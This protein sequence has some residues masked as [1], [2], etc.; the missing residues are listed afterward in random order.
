MPREGVRRGGAESTLPE[1]KDYRTLPKQT[2]FMNRD[3]LTSSGLLLLRVTFGLLMLNHG[4]QK[5]SGY[6]E[7]AETFPDPLG[8]GNQLSLIA[9]IGAELGCSLLLIAGLGTRLASLPLAFT[10]VIALFVIH[11]DDPWQKKE[12]AACYLAVYAVIL[13]TGPGNFSI[14][15]IIKRRSDRP[16]ISPKLTEEA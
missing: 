4:W 10:M 1:N 14:D 13:L 12:L 5:L 15:A 8:M 11:G 2:R 6:S 16:T 7:M 9:A 3:T